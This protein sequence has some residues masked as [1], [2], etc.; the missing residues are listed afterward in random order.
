MSPDYAGATYSQTSSDAAR[1]HTVRYTN[2]LCDACGKPFA[3]DVSYEEAH[4]FGEDGLC[5]PCGYQ[6][7]HAFD[8]A[9]PALS[10]CTLCPATCKHAS[11]ATADE[12]HAYADD[13]NG[14]THTVAYTAG[15]S[16]CTA[17]CKRVLDAGT[18]TQAS[19]AHAY[20]AAGKCVCGY[21]L[22]AACTHE[23]FNA[24]TYACEACGYVC[25]HAGTLETVQISGQ[26]YMKIDAV[27]H[28]YHYDFAA[29]W[30]PDCELT[31]GGERKIERK[32]HHSYNDAG[33]CRCGH[34]KS[35]FS[36][37]SLFD[38]TFPG[39]PLPTFT[40]EEVL[41]KLLEIR[42]KEQDNAETGPSNVSVVRFLGEPRLGVVKVDLPQAAGQVYY[43]ADGE[44]RLAALTDASAPAVV[45][46]AGDLSGSVSL[47]D[48]PRAAQAGYKPALEAVD[49]ALLYH[50]AKTEGGQTT[51][52]G[53]ILEAVLPKGQIQFLFEPVKEGGEGQ[54]QLTLAWAIAE[55]SDDL[56]D[57]IIMDAFQNREWDDAIT[58][59]KAFFSNVN[60]NLP[61]LQA[62][63]DS[64]HTVEKMDESVR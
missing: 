24:D 58:A 1:Y 33:R 12:G 17:L 2:E 11:A 8:H 45:T 53:H 20:D 38:T 49:G 15:V 50:T 30:C 47:T 46:L 14:A 35:S 21:Q 36:T 3:K 39:G 41:R 26:T 16:R 6:C 10:R 34:I 52:T 40:D 25:P 51:Y 31:F 62:I 44:Q 18:L 55:G 27:Y 56:R 28:E 48:D 64:L 9:D 23:K 22:P 60:A 5:A 32:L 29:K 13:K 7:L 61:A 37:A 42:Q 57:A 63:W 4:A 19:A 54:W 43:R 59:L